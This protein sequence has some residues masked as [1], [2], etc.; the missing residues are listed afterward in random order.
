MTIYL[1]KCQNHKAKKEQQNRATQFLIVKDL[2]TEL[3][4]HFLPP[5]NE[6]CEG[7]VFTGVCLSMGGCLPH[8]M[9]G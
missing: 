5:A 9:L 2:I 7:Y 1:I 8:C 6:V 3:L 4:C